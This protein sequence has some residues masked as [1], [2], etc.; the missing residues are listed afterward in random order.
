MKLL[1]HSYKNEELLTQFLEEIS[2]RN[3][4]SIFIQLF[5]GTT[6]VK[7]IQQVLN[8]I[9]KLAPNAAIIGATSAGEI[10]KGSFRTASILL[11]VSLFEKTNVETFYFPSSG[12]EDGVEAAKTVLKENTKACII[13]NEGYKSDSEYFLDGFTSISNDVMVAGGNASDDLSFEKSYI[14]HQGDIY[15]DGI[16]LATLNSDTLKVK[17][18]YSFS[19]TP[20]GKQMEVT[21][22]DGNCVCEINNTPIMEIYA[23]YLGKETIEKLP[24]S[25]A[26]FP[27]VKIEQDIPIA[28]TMIGVNK[29][30][31]FIY[32]G[33]FNIG[34][35][36]KFAIG[37]T[38]EI[39]AKSLEIVQKSNTFSIEAIYIY[40]CVVRRL[41]LQEQI[42]YE[43]SNINE[44]A[45]S[46]GF[47]TY[48]E[49]YYS[50]N[51]NQNKLLNITTT[52]LALSESSTMHKTQQQKKAKTH[53]HS[54]LDSLT[55]LLNITQKENE[56]NI[57]L[58]KQKDQKLQMQIL[59][60]L[61]G[62]KNRIAFFEQI[63]NTSGSISLLL[64][65]IDNFSEIND[66]YGHWYGD[67]VLKNFSKELCKL[68]DE[69]YTFR[70]GGD[71]FAVI[72]ENESLSVDKI[73]KD[74]TTLENQQFVLK[75]LDLS[76]NIT[77]GLAKAGAK[78]VYGLAHIALKNAKKNN[79]K[80]FIF[81]QHSK[82]KA[83][84]RKNMTM[85]HAI[86]KAIQEDCIVPYYQGI[87][88]N[89]TNQI[90]KYEALIRMIDTDGKI[91]TPFYFLEHAKKA[92][93]YNT[94][95]QIMITKVFKQFENFPKLS[96]SI[97]LTLQDI[98]CTQ[99]TTLLFETLK[100]SAV[101]KN[102][103]FEIV[104]SEGIENFSEVAN[105]IAQLREFGCKIAI[106]DFGTG[107]SN[108]SYLCKLD[109]DFLKID[110][111]LIKDMN[112]NKD[113][114]LTVE[115]VLFFAQKK[116]IK[117]VAEFVEN[118]EVFDT[119]CSQKVDYSQGYLFSKPSPYILE[120]FDL[121]EIHQQKLL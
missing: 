48:G 94:L 7:K 113:N 68:F 27:L 23:K 87:L 36:V 18:G 9:E 95:T 63:N 2:V 21:K 112:T 82:F 54:M 81:K 6:E 64:I 59:D 26:E 88:D 30:G 69:K 57:R 42:N 25:A 13:F 117:T 45:P 119:L 98:Q 80:F 108:F 5:S 97:N 111:S 44:I 19:W 17:N 107:Y 20:I 85:V 39:L 91:L 4:S 55:H 46:C 93:L 76:V 78:I 40:S 120:R 71:E 92:K 70:V 89:K 3:C 53:K 115:S 75:D 84:I 32:A 105:F 67:D 96:F 104:E 38:E 77:A 16:V 83:D 62:L 116:N 66:Y 103:V 14:I 58:L 8:Q 99:T 79:L 12:Y 52:T 72:Y 50:Q 86:K 34:D 61:T 100:H 109:I 37:N 11:S 31:C 47:F 22:V 49:F 110:G 43:L 102:A 121:S 35:K 10:A 73:E 29:K 101:A 118:K 24:L 74:L 1:T 65:N 60:D 56:E 114:L 33:H 90:T 28:R 51:Q 15:N 106:D 41:F